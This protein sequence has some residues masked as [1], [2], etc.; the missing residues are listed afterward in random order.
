MAQVLSWKTSEGS[1]G[2]GGGTTYAWQTDT[3]EQATGWL[4]SALVLTLAET[5]ADVDGVIVN[6]QNGNLLKNIDYS[7]SGTTVTILFAYDIDPD[8]TGVIF[9][10]QY[11]YIP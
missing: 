11:P 2:G 7:I 9:Q 5:P 1:G 4:P 6:F 10:F 8:L 3:F